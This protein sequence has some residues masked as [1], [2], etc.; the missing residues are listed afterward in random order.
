MLG[1]L[2]VVPGAAASSTS[3]ST[4]SSCSRSRCSA[5]TR[6]PTTCSRSFANGCID[7]GAAPPLCETTSLTHG[8]GVAPRLTEPCPKERLVGRL[9]A[10]SVA[11][12]RLRLPTLVRRPRPVPGVADCRRL[13]D[14][15]REPRGPQRSLV[16]DQGCD[17]RVGHVRIEPRTVLAL[18]EW[19]PLT[20]GDLTQLERDEVFLLDRL[21]ALALV[22][23]PPTIWSCGRRARRPPTPPRG[24]RPVAGAPAGARSVRGPAGGATPRA[25]TA[26]GR[27]A[28]RS[29]TPA[30]RP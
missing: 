24:T 19:L 30:R 26:P 27:A 9:D 10:S 1:V 15:R 11:P 8:F 20:H 23:R 16:V 12:C 6:S 29:A 5:A 22:L 13:G 17:V 14:R 28:N 3:T 7:G 25:A 18:L 4:A 2:E 21:A